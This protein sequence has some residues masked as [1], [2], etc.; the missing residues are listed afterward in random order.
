MNNEV[1]Q[2]K[3]KALNSKALPQY[4]RDLLMREI[5]EGNTTPDW[6]KRVSDEISFVESFLKIGK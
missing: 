1:E 4:F 2:L 6:A 3:K 5:E